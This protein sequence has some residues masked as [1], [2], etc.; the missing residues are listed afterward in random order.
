MKKSRKKLKGMT[1]IEMIISIAIFAMMGSLLVLVGMHI[2]SANKASNSLRNKIVEESPYAANHV[3]K[4]NDSTNTLKDISTANL[5]ITVEQDD[6]PGVFENEE[7]IDPNDPSKG[8]HKVQ[9]NLNTK[10]DMTAKKYQTRDVLLDGKTPTQ[11]NEIL[12]GANSNL[13]LEFFE[14]DDLP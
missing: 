11:K 13:N 10:V 14:I 7:Y 12:N 2:D 4:Y 9:Y 1:L 3:T 5:A 8:T 6:I